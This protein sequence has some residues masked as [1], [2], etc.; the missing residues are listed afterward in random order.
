MRPSHHRNATNACPRDC[1]HPLHNDLNKH[2]LL[3]DGEVLLSYTQLLGKQEIGLAPQGQ[4]YHQS[5]KAGR[6][7][8]V[9]KKR[10]EHMLVLFCGTDK[11]TIPKKTATTT[12]KLFQK[13]TCT[14]SFNFF[15]DRVFVSYTKRNSCNVK[16]CGR[17]SISIQR[18]ATC[19]EW[20]APQKYLFSPTISLGCING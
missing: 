1:R 11:Q 17:R 20:H 7:K 8:I 9:R 15:L 19:F 14:G 4:G 18:L 2:L 13:K 16:R 6:N 3:C 5:T 12:T 10:Q